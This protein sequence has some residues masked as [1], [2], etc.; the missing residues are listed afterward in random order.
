MEAVA[1][2][3][4]QDLVRLGRSSAG[5]NI[6]RSAPDSSLTALHLGYGHGARARRMV[7]QLNFDTHLSNSLLHIDSDA[8]PIH[9]T[10]VLPAPT[11]LLR[12]V[13]R[14]RS[15]IWPF[16]G[17]AMKSPRTEEGRRALEDALNKFRRSEAQES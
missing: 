4:L 13:R 10:E 14:G 16:T 7:R 17:P 12:P 15:L 8:E 2:P 9:G 5:G 1:G 3:S 6:I 11:R